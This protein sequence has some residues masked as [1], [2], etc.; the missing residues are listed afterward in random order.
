[1]GDFT[2]PQRLSKE[3]TPCLDENRIDD[4]NG[5]DNSKEIELSDISDEEENLWLDNNNDD[6]RKNGN[7]DQFKFKRLTRGNRDRNYRENANR[8]T[9]RRN[10]SSRLGAK[11]IDNSRRKEIERYN[12]RKVIANREFSISRSRSRTHSPHRHRRGSYSPRRR[13][14]S[15]KT[16][17]NKSHYYS[18]ISPSRH[19]P[20]PSPDRKY[21]R[22]YQQYNKRSQSPQEKLTS[23][24]RS[25]SKHKHSKCISIECQINIINKFNYR[26]VRRQAKEASIKRASA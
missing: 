16:S 21:P 10:M 9:D 19:S 12:V 23:S 15:P 4:D 3:N 2:P 26:N 24:R 17:R 18:P 20:S 5:G 11:R 14:I 7:G 8:K 13:S 22:N 6:V 1:M 25:R